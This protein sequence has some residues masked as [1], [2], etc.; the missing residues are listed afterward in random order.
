M[1]K[2]RNGIT[3]IALIITV[4][5]LLILAGTAVTIAI[6]G[7]DI[8]GKA[9]QARDGWNVAVAEE[10][11]AVSNALAIFDE[12][13]STNKIDYEIG[14]FVDYTPIPTQQTYTALAIHTGNGTDKSI[15]VGPNSTA[16]PEPEMGWRVLSINNDGTT[17]LIPHITVKGFTL[18]GAAGYNNG[19]YLLNDA[20][21]VLY[22]NA[23]IGATARSINIEDILKYVDDTSAYTDQELP[24]YND[25]GGQIGTVKYGS[26]QNVTRTITYPKRWEEDNG[27]IGES[28]S[29]SSLITGDTAVQETSNI[30]FTNTLAKVSTVNFKNDLYRKLFYT[31]Y[32]ELYRWRLLDCDALC[33]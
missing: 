29:G 23:S 27:T 25:F 3:L 14:D 1:E 2:K 20:C 15:S 9:T 18:A 8:F 26:T 22:S 10:Q 24:Q 12:F 33:I 32:R 28:L 21:R 19:V 7:G 17:E 31:S 5:I 11:S 6:N 4:I 13:E 30:T 16:N